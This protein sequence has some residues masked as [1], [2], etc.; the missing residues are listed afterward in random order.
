MELEPKRG[1]PC[2]GQIFKGMGDVE[3]LAHMNTPG[4][5]AQ[6]KPG[7][8]H[9]PGPERG[10]AKVGVVMGEFKRGTLH[11][12]SG[13]KVTNPRQAV[14]IAMSEAGL[15]KRGGGRGRR[16]ACGGKRRLDG[17]GGGVGN[18]GTK[19]QPKRNGK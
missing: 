8:Y 12:G 16:G 7:W 3:V 4:E 5:H 1:V 19:R 10:K 11:S 14:A 15:S 9:N 6:H 17:S 18:Y 2:R 13:E